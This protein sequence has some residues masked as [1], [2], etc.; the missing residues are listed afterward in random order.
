MLR[1]PYYCS[2]SLHQ[3]SCVSEWVPLWHACKG[4][5]GTC[6]RSPDFL[7]LGGSREEDKRVIDLKGT[8]EQCIKIRYYVLACCRVSSAGADSKLCSLKQSVWC[9]I[10]R[11][12]IQVLGA[13]GAHTGSTKADTQLFVCLTDGLTVGLLSSSLFFHQNNKAGAETRSR[14]NQEACVCD[15][16]LL[17]PSLY[18][19]S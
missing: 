18:M 2:R 17:G 13:L 11:G 19:H 9:G 1:E 14:W 8:L 3:H 5:R 10:T 6:V 16:C 7:L 15:L 4:K 12:G